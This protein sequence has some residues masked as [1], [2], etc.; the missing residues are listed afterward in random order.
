M[1]VTGGFSPDFITPQENPRLLVLVTAVAEM[2]RE[3]YTHG[4]KIITWPI[5]RFL[6]NAKT[7]NYIP[8][9]IALERA[10]HEGAVEAVYVDRNDQVLEGTTSN[11]FAFIGGKLVTP[12]EDVL[13]GITRQ[14]VLQLA[15]GRF[16]CEIRAV[17]VTELKSAEEVF[18]T[19]SN[20]E[21]VP[22]VQV[23]DVVVADGKPGQRSRWILEA[24]AK[25]TAGYAA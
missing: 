10:R 2:P 4:A 15:A 20:K 11:I 16:D 7:I 9:I 3:W 1:V 6:P 21:V 17:H 22:V 13:A 19:S 23:D 8:A 24:F 18:I 14:V 25:F 12:G 5:E